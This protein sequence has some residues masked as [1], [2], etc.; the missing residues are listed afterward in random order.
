VK[1]AKSAVRAR[2]SAAPEL[3]FEDNQRMT[4]FGGLVV[5][6]K[7]FASVGLRGLL[8]RSCA[9]LGRMHSHIYN[10]NTALQCLIVHLFLGFRKLRDF[11]YYREDPIFTDGQAGMALL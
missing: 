1:I 11:D 10:H 6:Q 8:Q 4:S 9:L 5:V 3:K 7:L 2:K